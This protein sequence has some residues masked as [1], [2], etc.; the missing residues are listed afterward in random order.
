MVAGEDRHIS[1]E[2][3]EAIAH[4]YEIILDAAKKYIDLNKYEIE[5]ENWSDK[6]YEGLP[7]EYNIQYLNVYLVDKSTKREIFI[8]R[9]DIGDNRLDNLTEEEIENEYVALY[10]DDDIR[11][12]AEELFKWW[13]EK[14]A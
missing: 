7:I 3:S 5:T 9:I 4:Y 14:G 6:V 11:E 2:Y 10:D 8:G 1:D 13:K 12:Q